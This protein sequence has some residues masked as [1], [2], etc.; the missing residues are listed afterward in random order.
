MFNTR[1]NQWWAQR[2]SAAVFL[3]LVLGSSGTAGLGA[4]QTESEEQ[5][6]KLCAPCHGKTGAG[7]GP[8]AVAF[9]PRP[10]SFVDSSFQN[11]HTDEQLI[12][13]ITDGKLPMPAF[14]KQLSA[15]QIEALVSYIRKLGKA[16]E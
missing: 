1:S 2:L 6:Q 9:T 11:S 15:N 12:A 5:Y 7:D 10:A 16:S 4:Q 13:T 8:A 14:G 3:F